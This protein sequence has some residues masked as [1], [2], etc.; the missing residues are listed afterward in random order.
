MLEEKKKYVQLF[1]TIIGRIIIQIL[2]QSH[3]NMHLKLNL[4]WDFKSVL[5]YLAPDSDS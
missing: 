5:I 3:K 1:C 2:I 4:N